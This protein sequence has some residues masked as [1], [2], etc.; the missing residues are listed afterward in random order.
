MKNFIEQIS[1]KFE[2]FLLNH[3]DFG[4]NCAEDTNISVKISEKICISADNIGELIHR[5][6]SNLKYY[7]Y[8]SVYF[9]ILECTDNLIDEH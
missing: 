1:I 6:V 3:D 4:T 5:S 7:I 2:G 9:L 8:F